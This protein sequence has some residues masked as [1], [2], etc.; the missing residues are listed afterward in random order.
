MRRLFK[1]EEARQAFM[2]RLYP[3]RAPSNG[4]RAKKFVKAGR[5]KEQLAEWS[6]WMLAKRK[7]TYRATC[8]ICQTTDTEQLLYRNGKP[9]ASA[10]RNG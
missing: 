8:R 1:N 7:R 6:R 5:T 4:P 2:R 9:S 3:E 10:V